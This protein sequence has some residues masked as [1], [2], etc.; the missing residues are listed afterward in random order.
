MDRVWTEVVEARKLKLEWA[1]S[2]LVVR[3]IDHNRDQQQRWRSSSFFKAC[4]DVGIDIDMAKY[5][6]SISAAPHPKSK[7]KWMPYPELRWACTDKFWNECEAEPIGLA[8]SVS[9]LRCIQECLAAAGDTN[10]PAFMMILERDV[11][12]EEPNGFLG[13]QVL[14]R[15]LL[16]NKKLHDTP[17]ISV[18]HSHTRDDAVQVTIAQ[19]RRGSRPSPADFHMKLSP[20]PAVRTKNGRHET[21]ANIGQG[22]R[23]YLLSM[24]FARWLLGQK[25]WSWFDVWLAG[26]VLAYHREKHT[27][28]PAFLWP[29]I[30][31]HPV[32]HSDAARGSDRL[33]NH[34]VN[35]SARHATYW[36]V[37]FSGAWGCSNR[38]HTLA[39][40]ITCANAC[41]V[42][43]HI[44]WL[45]KECCPG[46]L[47]DIVDLPATADSHPGIP[48][49][50]VHSYGTH[51]TAF[52][53]QRKMPQNKLVVDFEMVLDHF[54][55]YA[56]QCIVE[57][58]EACI[59]P[60][61]QCFDDIDW[62]SAWK[63]LLPK[64][65]I[66]ENVENFM[67]R[68]PM[69]TTQ[70]SIHVRRS[71]WMK[72]ET[73]QKAGKGRPLR[74]DPAKEQLYVQADRLVEDT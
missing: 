27:A 6:C 64:Q 16:L 48:F 5:P 60:T 72:R 53:N 43:L 51:Y 10:S 57:S 54:I 31:E 70:I 28:P 62:T 36:C 24:D 52:A 38:L 46:A 58:A 18:V 4:R 29:A 23:G 30:G 45:P 47:G 8:I 12:I 68:W 66:T 35:S 49:M 55:T 20:L 9:H 56:R 69:D 41:G 33:L 3:V 73:L 17:Y 67:F 42:G 22:A 7:K 63:L 59:N 44:Q 74:A 26:S 14:L 2:R 71:D 21:L 65:F 61:F 32:A 50:Q 37:Q 39:L 11:R 1:M 34:L 15:M 25:M 40:L 13:V 19:T